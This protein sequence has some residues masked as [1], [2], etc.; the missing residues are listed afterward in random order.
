MNDMTRVLQVRPSVNPEPKVVAECR[1]DAS[2]VRAV[3]DS[4]AEMVLRFAAL[5]LP[6]G[7]PTDEGLS[8]NPRRPRWS[9]EPS[10]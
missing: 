4:Q 7:S 1:L 3:M 6:I 2:L 8:G 10:A 5:L 9:Q